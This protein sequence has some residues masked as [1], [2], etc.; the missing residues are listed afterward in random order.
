M[1][2]V[3]VLFNSNLKPT[4]TEKSGSGILQGEPVGKVLTLA[5]RVII[6][7]TCTLHV[8]GP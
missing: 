5:W 4:S 1:Y 2:S 7:A 8:P 6:S 3:R